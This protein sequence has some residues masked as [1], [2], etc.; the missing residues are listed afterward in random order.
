MEYDLWEAKVRYLEVLELG[1]SHKA[2][3]VDSG[4]EHIDI[5][6]LFSSLKQSSV[7]YML[8]MLLYRHFAFMVPISAIF[9]PEALHALRVDRRPDGL[10]REGVR[11]LGA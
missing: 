9:R 4:T 5:L 1:S 11:H 8:G 2:F 6:E 3:L 7:L 10:A